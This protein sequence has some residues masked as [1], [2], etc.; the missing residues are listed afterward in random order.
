VGLESVSD[1]L[2]DSLSAPMGGLEVAFGMQL[3]DTVGGYVPWH[4]SFVSFSG[5]GPAVGVPAGL[6]G[7]WAAAGVADATLADR[8]F[9]GGGGGIGALNHPTGPALQLRAGGY[10]LLSR[11]E[12]S[13]RRTGLAVAMDLRLIDAAGITGTDPTRSVGYASF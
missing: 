9:V 8:F 6:P 1:E 2:G 7:T 5:L 4:L 13:P 11:K 10:P 12:N 3:N